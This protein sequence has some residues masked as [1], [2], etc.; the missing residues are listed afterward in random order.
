M[1]TMRERFVSV[2]NDLLERDPRVALVLADISTDRFARALR[3]HPD[4][5]INVGIREQLL[6]SVAGGLALAGLRPIAH[7]YAPFLVQ[8][9]F[10]QVKLDLGHQGTGAVLVSIGASYDASDS[11]R[12]HHAPEDVALIDTLPDWSIHVPGHAEEVD[13]LLSSAVAAR[14]GSVYIRLGTASNAAAHAEGKTIVV[15]RR[16]TAAAPTILAVGPMLAPALQAV[17]DLDVNVLYA[18]TIRPFDGATLRAI[19]GAPEVILVEPMLAGTSAVAVTDA[20]RDRPIRLLS[21]GVG[22]VELRRYGSPREHAAAHGLDPAGLRA[23]IDA[24]LAA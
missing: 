21:L 20:L 13:A 5:V 16:G 10:E 1:T 2:T 11:G 23:S 6:V 4:R 18:A 19:A 22:K 15:V 9:P 3:R 7:T 8:R 12:T 17:E 14:Q 24:F